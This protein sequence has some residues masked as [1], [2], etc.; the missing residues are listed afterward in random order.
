MFFEKKLI[1][2]HCG[3]SKFVGLLGK[4]IMG[5]FSK[6]FRLPSGNPAKF[7]SALSGGAGSALDK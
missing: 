4:V 3:R 7:C 6:I 5:V 1:V 2:V